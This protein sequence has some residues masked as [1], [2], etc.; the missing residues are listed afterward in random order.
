MSMVPCTER[1]NPP[2]NGFVAIPPSCRCRTF[3][4]GPTDCHGR[5]KQ[6][7]S[8]HRGKIFCHAPPQ[9]ALHVRPWHK[10]LARP[11]HTNHTSHPNV[12]KTRATVPHKPHCTAHRGISFCHDPLRPAICISPWRSALPRC[13]SN[14][15]VTP[16]VAN[17]NATPPQSMQSL[18]APQAESFLQPS[19]HLLSRPV[20]IFIAPLRF[21]RDHQHLAAFPC[22]TVQPKELPR[23]SRSTSVEVG[24]S[25]ALGYGNRLATHQEYPTKTEG[26][27]RARRSSDALA[28]GVWALTNAGRLVRRRW[29]RRIRRPRPV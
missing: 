11:T 9:T 19:F 15:R 21:R 16:I 20:R 22:E 6:A 26:Q 24:N 5:L 25:N 2:S 4:A 18:T 12:A 14:R 29:F 13:S 17:I 27:W 23:S 8:R 10:F 1:G 3:P 7:I 28:C